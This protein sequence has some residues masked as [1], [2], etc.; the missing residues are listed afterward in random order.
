MDCLFD[1]EGE[2]LPEVENIRMLLTSFVITDPFRG[3]VKINIGQ[4]PV[5]LE[6]FTSWYDEQIIKKD[7]DS[8]SV[9]DFVKRFLFY[10]V[11][12]VFNENCINQDSVKRLMF[13]SSNILAV[14]D[15][16]NNADPFLSS[17]DEH[18]IVN[19]GQLYDQGALPLPT[20]VPGQ[21]NIPS[22]NF[23]S[24]LTIFSYYRDSFHSGRGNR[25][26]DENKGVYHFD[27]GA[28]KGLVKKVSFSKTDIEYLRESRMFSQGA[29]GLL[30]LSSVYRCTI[31]MIGNTLLYPGMEM[32]VNPFGIGGV[33]FGLPQNGPGLNSD[34]NLSNIMGLGG[35]QQV[36]KTTSTIKPGSFTTT[37]DAHFIYSGAE[38]GL[39]NKNG[40]PIAA[41][42]TLTNIAN[43]NKTP[44]RCQ[45]LVVAAQADIRELAI[46]G[47]WTPPEDENGG[48]DD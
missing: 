29:N 20:S 34:P 30:Q 44:N 41:C 5:D 47:T 39:T 6:T 3:D 35:Y 17:G 42:D 26:S 8:I 24:Y 43:A 45:E 38:D 46:Y 28:K 14:N 40:K 11:A 48:C 1:E 25:I 23:Y 37:V 9:V 22:R 4:I 2:Y 18:P 15:A 10:L 19:A 31:D 36:L 21:R 12:N 32:W 13:Q 16:G 33:Q 7:S 27:I